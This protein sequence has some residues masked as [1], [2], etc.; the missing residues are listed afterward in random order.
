MSVRHIPCGTFVNESE[1]IAVERLNTKLQ[2]V[3]SHWVLLSNLNHAQ[4]SRYRSDEI[5]IVAIGGNGVYVIEVKHWDVAF[6]RKNPQVAELE[7]DRI[8][9]KAKRVAGRLRPRFDVG[10]VEARLLLTRGSVRFDAAKRTTIRGVSAFGLPEWSELLSVGGTGRLSK[11]QVELAARTLE[12]TTKVALSGDLRA[13]AGLVNLERQSDKGMLF[14][15]SIVDSIPR[16]G[17]ELSCICMIY[18]PAISQR[19]WNTPSGS[20]RPSSFG[21]NRLCAESAGFLPRG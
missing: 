8:N 16:D 14:I 7:A 11:D 5:D 17:I 21:R 4:H 6:I 2:S 9:A 1:R 3:D 20:S 18:P 10:F 19:L 13:F 15:G 12:P